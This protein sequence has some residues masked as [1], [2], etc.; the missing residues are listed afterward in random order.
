MR[1]RLLLDV[2]GVLNAVTGRPGAFYQDWRNDEVYGF[3]ITWSPT[4]ANFVVA[5]Q[6]QGVEV[7][8]LTTWGHLANDHLGPVLHLPEYPVLAEVYDFPDDPWWKLVAIRDLHE[9][10]PIPFVWIDDDIHFD[11]EAL[12]WLGTLPEGSFLAVSPN[13]REGILPEH[14]VT[15]TA[16]VAAHSKEAA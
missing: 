15:I 2:D 12:E 4:V 3:N 10:D 13:T 6:D 9:S 11:P 8:W 14:I 5:L 7:Q 16:F 1:V